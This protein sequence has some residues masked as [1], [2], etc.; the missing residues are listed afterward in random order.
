MK[1]GILVLSALTI[2]VACNKD[3]FTSTPQVT[4]TSITPTTVN[5]G[6]VITM[7]GNYTD[8]EGDLDSVLVVYKWYNGATV[9]KKDTFRYPFSTTGVPDKTREAEI[10]IIYEYNT[11]NLGIPFLSGLA[12]DTTATLGLVL[13]DKKANRSVYNESKQIRIKKP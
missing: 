5:S 2:L 4:I 6:N 11:N 1:A 12:K 9:V 13:K 8:D 3:K 7:T 10:K